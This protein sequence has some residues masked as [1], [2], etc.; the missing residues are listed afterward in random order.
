MVG[1]GVPIRIQHSVWAVLNSLEPKYRFSLLRV[2]WRK[3]AI[4]H[5]YLSLLREASLPSHISMDML[6]PWCLQKK[7]QEIHRE[8]ERKRDYKDIQINRS[9]NYEIFWGWL[10]STSI[11]LIWPPKGLSFPTQPIATHWDHGC[12]T[13]L[14]PPAVAAAAPLGR[15]PSARH[16]RALG[17]AGWRVAT[18]PGRSGIAMMSMLFCLIFHRLWYRCVSV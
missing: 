5:R 8:R 16:A 12:E 15:R 10:C 4:N 3:F 7:Q 2:V 14:Q 17:S 6:H 11:W 1:V 13:V 9:G 18:S